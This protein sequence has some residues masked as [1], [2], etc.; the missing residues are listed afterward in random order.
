[1]TNTAGYSLLDHRRNER[2]F[3]RNQNSPIGK[4]KWLNHFSRTGVRA[5]AGISFCIIA[6]RPALG[7]TSYSMN[8]WGYFTGGKLAVA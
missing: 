7:P 4:E 5:G 6:S 2:H 1:M 3:R 8:G